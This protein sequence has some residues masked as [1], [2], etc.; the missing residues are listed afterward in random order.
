M[1]RK[2]TVG[3]E[4]DGFSKPNAFNL[5]KQKQIIFEITVDNCWFNGYNKDNNYHNN[6]KTVV[7]MKTVDLKKY[8]VEK[9]RQQY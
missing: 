2:V 4:T 1:G 6:K 5:S 7:L 3:M 9:K 8:F